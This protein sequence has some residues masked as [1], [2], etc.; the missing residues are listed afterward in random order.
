MRAERMRTL[1]Q[2]PDAS[3]VSRWSLTFSA[4][5]PRWRRRSRQ[6]A[7][8]LADAASSDGHPVCSCRIAAMRALLNHFDSDLASLSLGLGHAWKNHIGSYALCREYIA[9]MHRVL[10]RTVDCQMRGPIS[11]VRKLNAGI[12]DFILA[13]RLC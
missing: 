7:G 9:H 12:L 3:P 10:R 11:A 4:S 1:P 5:R 6:M 13:N 8:T 2:Q